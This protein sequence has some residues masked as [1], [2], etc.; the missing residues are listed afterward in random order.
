MRA[1]L[2]EKIKRE[3]GKGRQATQGAFPGPGT[4]LQELRF[5]QGSPTMQGGCTCKPASAASKGIKDTSCSGNA[6]SE[7]K[8]VIPM[9]LA[10]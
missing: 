3:E 9:L 5:C 10:A 1:V 7:N 6:F 8:T 4:A 2:S